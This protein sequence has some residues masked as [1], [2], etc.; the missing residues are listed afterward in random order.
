MHSV[1]ASPNSGDRES[2]ELELSALFFYKKYTGE[3]MKK[4]I[5]GVSLVALLSSCA[6]QEAI[7]YTCTKESQQFLT[8]LQKSNRSEVLIKQEV[9]RRLQACIDYHCAYNKTCAEGYK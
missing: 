4:F 7:R 3:E 6:S 5:V 9:N 1:G 8:E 2:I